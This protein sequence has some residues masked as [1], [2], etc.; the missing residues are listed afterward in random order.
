MILR[1]GSATKRAAGRASLA[2]SGQGSSACAAS[3]A[4]PTRYTR[5]RQVIE[6][7]QADDVSTANK[8]NVAANARCQYVWG[9]RYVDDIVLRDRDTH[10]DGN[11]TD[12]WDDERLFYLHDANFNV[13]AVTDD[14]ANVVERYDYHPYG[15]VTIYNSD[16][17]A[18]VS[19]ANS[20][21][22]EILYCGY[23]FD[24]ETGSYHVRHRMYHPT[25]GRWLQ[26]DPGTTD[27]GP[28]I[29][30]GEYADGMNRYQYGRTAPVD[31][32]DAFG[33]LVGRD[34]RRCDNPNGDY[35]ELGGWI[36][37]VFEFLIKH[38]GQTD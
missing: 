24:P 14:S 26:R 3:A 2:L 20:R 5:T 1:T 33:L 21:K 11:C 36:Q 10:N 29:A 9:A 37:G 34:E 12:D 16:W 25:L 28:F 7:R 15:Q 17:S 23:R 30:S 22:N 32:R 27:A 19:W 31:S 35:R 13:V 18:T 6:E 8:D 38:I 4:R